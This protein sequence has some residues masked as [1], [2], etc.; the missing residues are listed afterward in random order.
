MDL[1]VKVRSL[2]LTL[3]ERC[4]KHVK[5]L[6][7]YRHGVKESLKKVHSYIMFTFYLMRHFI[8]NTKYQRQLM[9]DKSVEIRSRIVCSDVCGIH[10]IWPVVYK[11]GLKGSAKGNEN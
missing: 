1:N 7:R 10:A 4:R 2:Q 8:M 5:A 9:Y 11:V 6:N 3:Q